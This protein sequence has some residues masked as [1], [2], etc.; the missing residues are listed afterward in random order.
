MQTPSGALRII[1]RKKNIFKLSQGEYIAVEKVEGIYSRE[2]AVEQIFVYGNSFESSLVA[3]VVPNVEAVR[4]WSTAGA[5]ATAAQLCADPAVKAKMLETM[6]ATA[7]EGK[8]KG[9]EQVRAVYLEPELFA[10]ENELLT[11]TFKL[12]RPQLQKK[13][14][15]E[16]DAMYAA[17]KK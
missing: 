3:V 17:M 16:I 12:K 4:S 1:D 10:V 13:Y 11:P 2:A 6:T 14:Q 5:G 9:F 15:A 7:K 8:L